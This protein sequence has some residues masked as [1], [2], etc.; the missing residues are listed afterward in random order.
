VPRKRSAERDGSIVLSARIPTELA[1]RL[2]ERGLRLRDLVERA[3]KEPPDGPSA[4]DAYARGVR[5]G[6]RQ[7]NAE[8][9]QRMQHA[10]RLQEWLEREAGELRVAREQLVAAYAEARVMYGPKAL[11]LPIEPGSSDGSW[12][13][14]ARRWRE[15]VRVG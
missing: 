1:E 3:V 14:A 12:S 11:S 13:A 9:R 15:A 8:L 2:R 6:R 4:E 7:A 5:E 10:A